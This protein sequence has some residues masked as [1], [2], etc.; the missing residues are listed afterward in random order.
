[1]PKHQKPDSVSTDPRENQ[2]ESVKL[3][4]DDV[5]QTIKFYIG[6]KTDE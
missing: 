2:T 6:E 5:Y 4:I 1:M 3:K